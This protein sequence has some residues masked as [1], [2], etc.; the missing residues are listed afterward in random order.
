MLVLGLALFGLHDK[1]RGQ[2][3]VGPMVTPTSYLPAPTGP[4]RVNGYLS[5]TI[6][7]PTGTLAGFGC[8]NL[9]V[10]A[11]SKATTSTNPDVYVPL[12]TWRRTASAAGT[13]PQCTF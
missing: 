7:A 1:A 3:L 6:A 2:V 13:W 10:V 8:S 5:A 11:T 9:V 12:P 4:A